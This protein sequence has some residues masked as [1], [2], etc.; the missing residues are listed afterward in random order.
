[1][2]WSPLPHKGT[3]QTGGIGN[4]A[5]MDDVQNRMPP[6]PHIRGGVDDIILCRC[7][8]RCVTH[9][10]EPPALTRFCASQTNFEHIFNAAR[11][12]SKNACDYYLNKVKAN[13]PPAYEK[14][15][16]VDP[17]LWAYYTRR[18]N[19]VWDQVTTNMAE[20]SN[21]M[22][23]AAVSIRTKLSAR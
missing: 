17:K 21:N 9:L 20:T 12:P 18:N 19:R 5:M 1:M 8:L 13:N 14:W 11:A 15:M 6:P 22:I 7:L 23:G 3:P 10:A 4:Y 16:E 2:V